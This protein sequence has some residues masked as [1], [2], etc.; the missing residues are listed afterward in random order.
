MIRYW[1]TVNDIFKYDTNSI[2]YTDLYK[3]FKLLAHF[4]VNRQEKQEF[5][6][7]QG[8]SWEKAPDLQSWQYGFES[9]IGCEIVE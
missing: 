9:D 1:A 6:W 8:N 7:V 5:W 3:F 4:I 2:H